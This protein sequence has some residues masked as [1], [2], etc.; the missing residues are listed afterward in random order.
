MA[1]RKYNT[2]A[3]RYGFNGMEIDQD[4][5][6]NYT[7]EHWEYEPRLGRRWNLDP[8]EAAN[9]SAYS[10][11]SGNPILVS[12]P[13]GDCP[14]CPALV[15]FI[16]GGLTEAGTQIAVNLILGK[17]DPLDLDYAD[18]AVA[19]VS[20]A[21]SQG[22]N[23]PLKIGMAVMKIN[24]AVTVANKAKQVVKAVNTGK[25]VILVAGETIKAT[26]DISKTHGTTTVL[27]GKSLGDAAVDLVAGVAGG[28]GSDKL[29]DLASKGSNRLAT[30]VQTKA[31][32][33]MMGS[34][35]RE[36]L[37]Q[38]AT[39]LKTLATIES[40]AV[41]VFTGIASSTTG[42]ATKDKLTDINNHSNNNNIQAT[43][44]E[45]PTP[46]PSVTEANKTVQPKKPT[47]PT[48]TTSTNS[49]STST[50]SGKVKAVQTVTR[51]AGGRKTVIEKDPAYIKR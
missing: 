44:N 24:R 12:D 8:V 22:T 48:N 29:S 20:G 14:F 42:S 43:S 32:K 38:Q 5:D 9:E 35:K 50:S 40:K 11:Y 45:M 10:T 1:G 39:D 47:P 51:G 7:A 25:T 21:V 46:E 18:I 41:E 26:V 37:Q 19:A 33:Y 3:Y 23:A 17:D 36:T 4:L 27:N 30:Q 49:S 2:S 34:A 16:T 15:G 13:N 31:N 6:G 28:K